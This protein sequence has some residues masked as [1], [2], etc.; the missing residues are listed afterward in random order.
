MR[1]HISE[2]PIECH[3]LILFESLKL[4]IVNYHERL[5]LPRPLLRVGDTLQEHTIDIIVFL[6]VF[7]IT[8]NNV[9]ALEGRILSHEDVLDGSRL[10]AVRRPEEHS[11]KGMREV[12]QVI[13]RSPL[14][15][16]L[17]IQVPYR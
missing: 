15:M 10:A 13:A 1:G 12:K 14:L 2:E 11:S 3:P 8:V 4:H 9:H 7:S 17:F 5:V 6:C 16:V